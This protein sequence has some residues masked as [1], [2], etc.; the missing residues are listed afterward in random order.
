MKVNCFFSKWSTTQV[1]IVLSW[2][3]SPFKIQRFGCKHLPI[4]ALYFHGIILLGIQYWFCWSWDSHS[5][6]S[7]LKQ[8][9][10]SILLSVLPKHW[11]YRHTPFHSPY[12][13]SLFEFYMFITMISNSLLSLDN[14]PACWLLLC[15]KSGHLLEHA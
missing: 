12:I 13:K 1:K 2:W 4:I 5:V 15:S 10:Q 11:D 7:T 9:S 14:I 3:L 6:W 8:N